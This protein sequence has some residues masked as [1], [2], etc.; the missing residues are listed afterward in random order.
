M[1]ESPANR[2]RLV[3]F[4]E[5]NLEPILQEWEDYARSLPPGPV[6]DVVALR[7]HAREML[8]A[9][10]DD[11]GSP[12]SERAREAKGKGGQTGRSPLAIA[13]SSHAAGRVL[14][15]F[16][17][18]ELVSE[19]RAI[20]ASVLRLWLRAG[21]QKAPDA[22]EELMRFNEAIDEAVAAS[23]ARYTREVEKSRHLLLGMLGH[24]LRNP[25]H[26]IRL[27]AEMLSRFGAQDRDSKTS[28]ERIL[29]GT[30]QIDRL[31]GTLIDYARSELVGQPEARRTPT[32]IGS[33]CSICVDQ[34]RAT[35]PQRKVHLSVTGDTKG[36]WDEGQ[37]H[38]MLM[39]LILN[40]FNHGDKKGEVSVTASGRDEDVTVTVHNRGTPIPPD[41]LAD[42]FRPL[43]ER[44]AQSPVDLTE[45]SSGLHLGLYIAQQVAQVHGGA[46]QVTSNA[47][48][49]TTF[50]V[51]LPKGQA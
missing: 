13:A 34:S 51:T 39:N 38:Q 32:D 41:T 12:Q 23:V 48:D 37:I 18:S 17:L 30:Y 3:D 8:V 25:L 43:H 19:F 49:G 46:I 11:L 50:T 45:G 14:E 16:T 47:E 2:P 5:E 40:A 6:L 35:N 33:I 10:V 28:V 4:I 27:S 22:E 20:R 1:S 15:R 29:N 26:L 21:V 42:L 24:D 36:S 44:L 7:D 9:L 31:V